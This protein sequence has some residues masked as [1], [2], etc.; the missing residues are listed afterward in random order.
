MLQIYKDG[1]F[2]DAEFTS[3][4]LHVPNA[5]TPEYLIPLALLPIEPDEVE[6]RLNPVIV[7][8]PGEGK[9]GGKGGRG[10]QDRE[11]GGKGKGKGGKGERDDRAAWGRDGDEGGKGKGGKGE[12]AGRE[13]RSSAEARTS[14]GSAAPWDRDPRDSDG[15]EA[16]LPAGLPAPGSSAPAGGVVMGAT[17]TPAPP[18]PKDWYYRDLEGTVQGPFDEALIAKWYSAGFLAPQL[19]MREAEQPDTAYK[20]LADLTQAGGGEP[21]FVRALRLRA[22]YEAELVALVK[23]ALDRLSS[24]V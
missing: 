11:G 6:L 22:K 13:G 10:F 12:R 4:F 7:G 3:K 5:T 20:S 16:A 17:P 21:P 8:N 18:P 19:M 23:G 2:K 15:A 24:R 9:G 1:H 14:G